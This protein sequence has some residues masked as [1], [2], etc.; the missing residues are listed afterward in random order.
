V[1]AENL[2][3]LAGQ[4]IFLL[5]GALTLVDFLRHRQSGRLDVA[6]MFSSVAV[7]IL[8]SELRDSNGAQLPWLIAV[9]NLA[10]VAQPYL[11]LRLVRYFRSVPG[12]VQTA[13]A[14]GLLASWILIVAAQPLPSASA[15]VVLVY[16]VF[17]EGYATVAFVR[18]AL[19]TTGVTHWR[20][21][22]AALGSGL[23][24][25][26]IFLAVAT[27]MLP[28]IAGVSN[29]LVR[30][31]IV[32]AALAY[33]LGF[34]PPQ[35]L[36]RAWQ[37]SEL[38]RFLRASANRTVPQSAEKALDQLC[39]SAT[40]AVGGLAGIVALWDGTERRLTT[41][42]SDAPKLRTSTFSTSDGVI[43]RAWQA[44]QPTVALARAAL[45]EDAARALGL[46]NADALYAVPLLS[47]ERAWGLLLVC[48]RRG[49]LF[50]EDDLDLLTLLAEQTANVLEATELVARHRTLV[51]AAPDAIV[52]VN[53]D[54]S[55]I[56]VNAQAE[57]LFGYRR[58]EL[59]GKPVEML[60][61]DRLQG[62]HTRHRLD[63]SANPHTRP[64]GIGLSLAG[65]CKDGREIPVEVTLSPLRTETEVYTISVVRDITERK[66]AQDKLR[67]E[68]DLMQALLDNLP[69][70]IYFK[71]TASRFIRINT[72][73]AAVLGV[74]EPEQAIGKT[75][76]D[77]QWDE[78][79]TVSRAEEQRIMETGEKVIDRIEFNPTKDGRPRWITSTKAPIRDRAG[80]IYG[81]VGISRDIT[82]QKQ[83]EDKSIN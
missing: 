24:A 5:L 8:L 29:S 40:R 22:L 2:L 25:A 31:G 30:S 39:R 7:S 78:I 21:S 37:L 1:S 48:L 75:D 3:T 26:V 9:G 73:Q 81:L 13:S 80:T 16:F 58:D 52:T 77:F 18:G 41:R 61:P 55:I 23:V 43:G 15:L 83:I 72:V 67:Y 36:R 10:L 33:Y 79:S 4:I 42:A 20:L 62:V 35:S 46:V 49:P 57:K 64:M 63:Y 45:G 50:V 17:V 14:V 65:R 19:T 44:R 12:P 56:L 47:G 60:L 70:M 53:Q 68:R 66:Q 34:V 82:E 27:A 51:E 74:A 11:L 28:D 59:L 54:G 76:F 6:L 71:D 38:Y 69:Y 32:L